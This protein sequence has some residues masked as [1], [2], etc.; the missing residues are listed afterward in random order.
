MPY[1]CSMFRRNICKN[2]QLFFTKQKIIIINICY[3]LL[4]FIVNNN[5]IK[6]QMV[7]IQY[8]NKFRTAPISLLFY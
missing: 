4:F 3:I 7:V 1:L 2:S 6:P 8:F 5:G